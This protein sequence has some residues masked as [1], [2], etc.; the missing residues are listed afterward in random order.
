MLNNTRDSISDIIEKRYQQRK[1]QELIDIKNKYEKRLNILQ[2]MFRNL[3]NLNNTINIDEL[4]IYDIE[5]K[6]YKTNSI[7]K[8]YEIKINHFQFSH[9]SS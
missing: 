7:I 3:F 9:N 5:M 1:L 8:E 2:D 6:I 4:Y